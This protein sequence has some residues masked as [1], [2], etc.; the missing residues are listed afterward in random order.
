M[1]KTTLSALLTLLIL[2]S[3]A[4]CGHHKSGPAQPTT[5]ILTLSTA[6]T[7]TSAVIGGVEA[8]IELPAGVTAK[9]SIPT[10]NPSIM[11]TDGGVVTASGAAAG[12]TFVHGMYSSAATPNTYKVDVSVGAP[13]N[14]FTAGNFATVNCD[15][16]AGYFPANSD[17]H[18][19]NYKVVDL[20]GATI[21][22]L[23]VGFSAVIQ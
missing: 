15:V 7:N 18:I 6:G 23:T 14:G 21:P 22:G 3:L 4:A 1:R 16:T 9:A 20:N 19:P 12:A 17:F 5:A 8:E 2:A 10:A 13:A 11:E